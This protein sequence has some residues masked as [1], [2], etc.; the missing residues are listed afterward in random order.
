MKRNWTDQFTTLLIFVQG[1]YFLFF[2]FFV[3]PVAMQLVR[4][5][6]H[7]MKATGELNQI[8]YSIEIKPK[9][10]IHFPGRPSLTYTEQ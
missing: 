1:D 7:Y 3:Q 8:F 9:H 6:N 2:I 5:A 10:D 4:F